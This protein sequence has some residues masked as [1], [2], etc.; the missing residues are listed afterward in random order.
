MM[1]DVRQLRDKIQ[2]DDQARLPTR[3]EPIETVVFMSIRDI[4]TSDSKPTPTK[5]PCNE[6]LGVS[7]SLCSL[8]SINALL[9]AFIVPFV[10]ASP[11]QPQNKKKRPSEVL[12]VIL[13][14]KCSR[15]NAIKKVAG[16]ALTSF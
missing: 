12:C 10:K 8:L 15:C 5:T 9:H 4:Q 2:Y 11:S 1:I 13:R 14:V 3:K 7:I 16:A 6:W